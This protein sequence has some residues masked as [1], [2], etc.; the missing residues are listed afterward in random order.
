M[1][2]RPETMCDLCDTKYL[3]GLIELVERVND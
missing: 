3:D 2:G 1:P